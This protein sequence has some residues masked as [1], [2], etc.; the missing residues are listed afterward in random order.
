[1]FVLALALPADA[2]DVWPDGATI[3]ESA[4]IHL[5]ADGLDALADVIPGVLPT[6]PTPVGDQSDSGGFSCV[7][8]AYSLTNAWVGMRATGASLTPAQG[9]VDVKIDLDVWLNDIND[10]FLLHYELFCSASDCPGYVTPFPVEVTVPFTLAV[11]DGP[12][13]HPVLDA[14]MGD[15]AVDNGLQGSNIQLDCSIG[16]I[17]QVLNFFGLSLY[18]LIISAAEGQIEQQIQ[19]QRA[20]LE[21]TI[22]D[23]L[24]AFH[25]DQDVDVNG[26]PLHV[27]LDP[28][29]TTTTPEGLVIVAQGLATAPPAACTDAYDAGG[30][31]A[32]AT[33]IPAIGDDPNRTQAGLLLSDDFANQ[34][35]YALWRGGLLC[36][37]LDENSANLPLTL[38]TSILGILGGDPFRTLWPDNQ[39]MTVRTDPKKAPTVAYDGSHD[40]AVRATDLGVDFYTVLDDRPVHALGLALDADVGVD[41]AFDD[42][43]GE[44]GINVALDSDSI[45][46]RV[47]ANEF[48]PGT[49][50]GIVTAFGGLVD[51]LLGSLLGPALGDLA[52]QI[53]S[54]SGLGL[55][56]L[57][58]DPAGGGDWMGAWA[59]I[60]QVTYTV[61]T[62]DTGA[63]SCGGCDGTRSGGV[64]ALAGL[65]AALASRRGRHPRAKALRE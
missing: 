40:V 32:T 38:D 60:G 5:T 39:P 21:Q 42:T 45:A 50:D 55:T 36:Y 22:E 23:A 58:V 3:D 34:A 37:Q 62:A 16:T 17:E 14:T 27:T 20:A 63:S 12:D 53:P 11:V 51:T 2:D 28:H 25:V 19:D 35:L 41:L 64:A 24:S 54:M 1:M 46:P 15:I 18:D 57:A 47:V 48:A 29:A 8:Y 59:G 65:L 31:L 13:G 6:E 52:F 30:S 10:K 61:D 26:V 33:P 43:T 56:S 9:H 44:L 49:E 4:A 7:N